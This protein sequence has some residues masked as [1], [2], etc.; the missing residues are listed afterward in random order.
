MS[1]LKSIEAMFGIW[2]VFTVCNPSR[3][4]TYL[5]ETIDLGIDVPPM[6]LQ[7]VANWL[8]PKFNSVLP[9]ADIWYEQLSRGAVKIS[10]LCEVIDHI[11]NRY[12]GRRQMD[13]GISSI[14]SV[15]PNIIINPSAIQIIRHTI[16]VWA[17]R[18]EIEFKLSDEMME[19]VDLRRKLLMGAVKIEPVRPPVM[20][21]NEPYTEYGPI[22]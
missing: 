6:V 15:E 20:R 7:R 19:T 8:Y 13:A 11:E 1:T 22:A 18:L 14:D 9:K 3:E 2:T 12:I 17:D 16:P 4:I 21:G 5:K 10:D